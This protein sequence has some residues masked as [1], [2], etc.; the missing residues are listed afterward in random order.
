[1][2]PAW[3]SNYSRYK[4]LFLTFFSRY[5][6]RQDVKMF[7]EILLS[8]ITISLF[9]LL[10][11]RPTLITIAELI[12][13]IESKK[14]TVAVM[15]AKIED[16]G[17]AQKL[18]DQEIRR[19][20]LLEDSVPKEPT[21][22]GFIRQIEGLSAKRA[23]GIISMSLEEVVILGK[24]SPAQKADNTGRLSFS[25]STSADYPQLYS[26]LKD[27]EKMRRPLNVHSLSVSTSTTREE[28][29]LVLVVD[30]ISPFLR[31]EFLENNE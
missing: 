9:S 19:I 27:L 21:P 15:D 22:E 11:L 13:D 26:F 25:V 10:A 1:M 2:G 30:G 4:R 12:I 20:K 6:E 24:E 23:V 14:G 16:L 3:R 18:Y 31:K 29:F 5:R 28:T 17:R 7:L 8:L